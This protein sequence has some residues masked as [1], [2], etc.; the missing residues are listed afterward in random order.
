MMLVLVLM[1]QQ[2]QN[3]S[4]NYKNYTKLRSK[5]SAIKMNIERLTDPNI[6]GEYKKSLYKIEQNVKL[7]HTKQEIWGNQTEVIQIS[8]ENSPAYKERIKNFGSLSLQTAEYINTHI[9][10]LEDKNQGMCGNWIYATLHH[11]ENERI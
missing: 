5:N 1:Q 7:S 3:S 2:Y 10:S 6:E 4:S 9:Q 8:V 11:L